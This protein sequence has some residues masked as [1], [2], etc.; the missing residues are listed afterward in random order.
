MG[1][2]IIGIPLR[3]VFVDA[4]TC[5]ETVIV[6]ESSTHWFSLT[7][8]IEKGFV[9]RRRK[10][11]ALEAECCAIHT[12]LENLKGNIILHSDRKDIVDYLNGEIKSS[13][14]EK[15]LAKCIK[16]IRELSKDRTIIFKYIP[17]KYNLATK[18]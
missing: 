5:S 14:I 7:P 6:V 1:K 2:R 3:H 18:E 9:S 15:K 13:K 17:R 12:A 8:Y 11:E 4:Q 16:E 10:K